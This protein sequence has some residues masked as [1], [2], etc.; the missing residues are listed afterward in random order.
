MRHLRDRNGKLAFQE[1]RLNFKS[2]FLTDAD[3]RNPRRRSAIK[4]VMGPHQVR[5]PKGPQL[6]ERL[7]HAFA[8]HAF[9][10]AA[11]A[12]AGYNFISVDAEIRPAPTSAQTGFFMDE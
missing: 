8:E 10:E 5:T 2:P 4:P 12:A 7:A 11:P 1:P 9:V 3:K 6:P